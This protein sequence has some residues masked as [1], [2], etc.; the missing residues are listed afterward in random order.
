[1][2]R[3]NFSQFY[4]YLLRKESHS[5]AEEIMVVG[6]MCTSKDCSVVLQFKH[7]DLQLSLQ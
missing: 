3:I 4:V 1:M 2:Q 5:F 7:Y 6:I